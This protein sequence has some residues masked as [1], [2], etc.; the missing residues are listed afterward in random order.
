MHKYAIAFFLLCSI[1]A[2]SQPQYVLI[3]KSGTQPAGCTDS[4]CAPINALTAG[5]WY[6]IPD[7][8]LITDSPEWN[9]GGVWG[10]GPSFIFEYSGGAFDTAN[11]RLLVRGGGHESYG[12]NEIY[13]F[14][15]DVAGTS[16]DYKWKRVSPQTS[17]AI[18]AAARADNPSGGYVD[19]LYGDGVTYGEALPQALHTW[20]QIQFNPQWNALIEPTLGAFYAEGSSYANAQHC[21]RFIA[22]G[23]S[24]GDP[25]NPAAGSWNVSRPSVSANPAC[26]SGDFGVTLVDGT[27]NIWFFQGGDST[28]VLEYPVAGSSWITKN[29]GASPCNS[30][31][32]GWGSNGGA[33]DTNRNIA[34]LVGRGS[35]EIP[36]PQFAVWDLS[37]AATPTLLSTTYTG[38][39]SDIVYAVGPS[40]SWDSATGLFVCWIGLSGHESDVYV[41]KVDPS[42][43]LYHFTKLPATS[44]TDAPLTRMVLANEGPHGRWAYSPT[45]NLY[46]L[47]GRV[48]GSAMDT[49]IYKFSGLATDNT[50]PS[51]TAFTTGSVTGSGPYSIAI[52][53]FTATDNDRVTGYAVTTTPVPPEAWSSAFAPTAPAAYSVASKGVY[54]LYGWSQDVHG[55]VSPYAIATVEVAT[56]TKTV[57]GDYATIAAAISWANGNGPGSIVQIDAASNPWQSWRADPG[58]GTTCR[59]A[60]DAKFASNNYDN[61]IGSITGSG[62]AIR[63]INGT[64]QLQW[65]CHDATADANDWSVNAGTTAHGALLSMASTAAG[66]RLEN[67]EISGVGGDG[68]G[69]AADGSGTLYIKNVKVHDNSG[70]GLLGGVFTPNLNVVITGS[71]FYDN[72]RFYE[73]SNAQYHNIYV[74]ESSSFTFFNST[75]REA[76]RGILVKSRSSKNYIAYSRLTDEAGGLCASQTYCSDKNI[77][78][79][80]GHESYI[81]GNIL[82]KS[83]KDNEDATFIS[84]NA[85]QRFTAYFSSGGT[86]SLTDFQNIT[87]SYG[88]HT[89]KPGIVYIGYFTGSWAAGTQNGAITLLRAD[90]SNLRYGDS[91]PVNG[92]VLTY[93]GGSI[94]ITAPAA[95]LVG[96]H[97]AWSFGSDPTKNGAYIVNNT[98]VNRYVTGSG[99]SYVTYPYYDAAYIRTRNNL[100]VDLQ[101]GSFPML[102]NPA[103][104]VINATETNN[105]WKTSDPGFTAINTFDYS[106]TSGGAAAVGIS[107][108][109]IPVNGYQLSPLFEYV[110]PATKANRSLLGCKGAYGYSANC[111]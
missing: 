46:V 12:G 36:T 85:E 100:F 49:R 29:C 34:V 99:G 57:P 74:G 80:Y 75:S 96:H 95:E 47:G 53:S 92:N 104:A 102:I 42:T 13:A 107:T 4:N 89:W 76:Y 69:I 44:V 98:F 110:S 7:T 31:I 32:T 26:P 68:V 60:S 83:A 19:G 51:V 22:Y 79:P 33:I 66:L 15:L 16:M 20:T 64:A 11:N 56:T 67:L 63:G 8:D 25:W 38:D 17:A 62:I 52:S 59:S 30:Q 82:E 109:A 73:N 5:Q 84:F 54:D 94:T 70:G 24:A 43:N 1:C 3:R 71:Q 48:N 6:A 27:G 81:V 41:L 39:G 72:A 108:V 87:L 55:N 78:L 9:P 10:M 35:S 40:I 86:A 23:F 50:P 106:L 61:V 111:N 45:Q 103:S 97:L 21:A 93:T 65:L 105:S 91:V 28:H 90:G 58:K 88:G 77:D 18:A 37:N 101:A 2:F 14:N